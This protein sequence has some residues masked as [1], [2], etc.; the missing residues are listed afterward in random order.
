MIE[1]FEEAL[2]GRALGLTTRQH[3]KAIPVGPLTAVP[4][5]ALPLEHFLCYGSSRRITQTD[6]A[7]ISFMRSHAKLY[8]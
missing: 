1:V 6:D 3:V 5:S 4:Y 2:A 8:W 7:F